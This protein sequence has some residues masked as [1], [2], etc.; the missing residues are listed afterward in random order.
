MNLQTLK[1]LN[2]PDTPGVYFFRKGHLDGDVLYI[3]KATSLR[4]R[5]KSYFGDDLIH[6]RG[7]LLVDMV[8]QAT[9]LTFEKTDSVLEAFLLETELIKKY[10][11]KYNTK[12]KDNKSFNYVVITKEEYPRVLVVRGR[13]LEQGAAQNTT[14]KTTLDFQYTDVF[15]PYPFGTEL[16]EA[17]KLIRKIFPYRDTCKPLNENKSGRPCFNAS[18]GLCPGVCDGRISRA[19]Y[20]KQVNNIRLFLKGKKKKLIKDLTR[21]MSA[22]S[23]KHEFEKASEVKRTIQAL[24]HIND[25]SMIKD[26]RRIKIPSPTRQSSVNDNQVENENVNQN[27]NVLR[28]EAYDIAHMSGKDMVG[29]MVV[30]NIVGEDVEFIKSEYKKFNIKSVN[31]ANDTGALKEVLERRIAHTEW[32]A[33]DMIVIDGGQAQLNVAESVLRDVR[34]QTNSKSQENVLASVILVSVLKDDRHKAKNILISTDVGEVKS[35]VGG[36]SSGEMMIGNSEGN[37]AARP[38]I[39]PNSKNVQKMIVAINAESHR[40]ALA[41]HTKKRSK[42]RGF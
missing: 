19:D 23:K 38:Q 2:L 32:P 12:E 34:S 30:A 13:N 39:D 31:G 20:L 5:V 6:T 21:Q 7:R 41:F 28:I 27:E 22:Y 16:R 10:Q 14:Q 35:E 11:P 40:F 36:K 42:S 9:E 29:V 17:L 24:T 3:G 18:I 1:I 25:I 8:T 4:D 15:G 37:A 33:P 26:D